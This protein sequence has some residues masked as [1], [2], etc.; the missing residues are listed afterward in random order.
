MK[1]DNYGIGIKYEFFGKYLMCIF[2]LGF[3]NV[4]LVLFKIF[5]FYKYVKLKL[6]YRLKNVKF[7]YI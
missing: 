6:V 4:D 5:F 7:C 1:N 2:M 3:L